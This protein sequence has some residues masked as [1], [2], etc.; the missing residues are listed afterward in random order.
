MSHAA[1]T[2]CM[3][4]PMSET[5]SA[6]RRF[7][8]VGARKGRHRLGTSFESWLVTINDLLLSSDVSHRKTQA[9]VVSPGR[10]TIQLQSFS[11]FTT[12]APAASHTQRCERAAAYGYSVI[13]R[14]H[15]MSLLEGGAP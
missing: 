4:V 11:G 3:K 13:S 2:L 9:T 1:P 6:T 14:R 15:S 7:R 5:T 8:N 12:T 10:Q